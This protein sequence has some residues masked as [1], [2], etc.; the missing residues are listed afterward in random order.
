MTF[1]IPNSRH[2]ST[3][4]SDSVPA[5]ANGPYINPP[6]Q[7]RRLRYAG[8][9]HWSVVQAEAA[10]RP[11]ITAPFEIHLDP[12]IALTAEASAIIDRA[13]SM[14]V[15]FD[16]WTS[17]SLSLIVD[18]DVVEASA[19]RAALAGLARPWPVLRVGPIK[20]PAGRHSVATRLTAPAESPW[21]FGTLLVDEAGAPV[22]RC[23]DAG[24]AL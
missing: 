21:Q 12:Q 4:G 5:I 3:D 6:I 8:Q 13:D 1:L 24:D 7:S 15:L 18:G 10:S 17:G 2:F 19:P 23:T 16:T 20:L 11:T 22:V 9:E 14:T